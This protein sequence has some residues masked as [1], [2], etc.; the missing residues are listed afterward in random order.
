A[1]AKRKNY[2]TELKN[3]EQDIREISHD[4]NREKSAVINNFEVIFNNLLEEQEVSHPAKVSY[5]ISKNIQ[6]EKISNNIKINIYRITQ[7]ALQNINKYASANTILITV[8]DAAEY[9]RLTIKDDGVG[10]DIVKK[11]KGIGLQ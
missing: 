8:V 6:W 11:S 1:E 3:I 7:E 10:F 2:L 5:S 9:I 4:L